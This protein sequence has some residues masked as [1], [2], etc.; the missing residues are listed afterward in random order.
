MQ[1]YV[2][3]GDNPMNR[4]TKTMMIAIALLLCLN[5]MAHWGYSQS[6]PAKPPKVLVQIATVSFPRHGN[7]EPGVIVYRA[8]ND[9]TVD[10]LYTG[11][12]KKLSVIATTDSR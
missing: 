10:Q 5:L 12:S 7:E 8:F 11:G 6:A 1:S 4:T 9:G 3:I 2:L